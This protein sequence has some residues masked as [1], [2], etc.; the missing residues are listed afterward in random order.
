MSMLSDLRHFIRRHDLLPDGARVV[1][2]VS[3]GP[4]S[5]ALLHALNQLVPEHNWQLHAAYLH[6]GLR[7]EADDEARFVAEVAAAWGLGCTF[8][9]ADV[10]AIAQ[11]PG[12]ALEEAARQARYAFL[13]RVALRLGAH[14]VAVG[15]NADDQAE[16]VLMHLL[17]GSG[18]AGLRGMSPSTPLVGFR[19]LALEPEKRPDMGDLRLVRPLLET[20]RSEIE[21]YCQTHG[22]EPRHDATNTDA[23]FFRNRLRHQIMPGLREINPR[24][25]TVLGRTAATLQGD[26]DTLQVHRQQLWDDMVQS[27]SGRVRIDLQ[28]FRQLLPGDQ[29][30]LLRR[31]VV[32]LRPDLRNISWEH[33]ER[34]LDILDSDPQRTSGG[35]YPLLAGLEAWLHQRWLDILPSDLPSSDQPQ[36]TQPTVLSP[37]GSVGLGP[38]W[39]LE[40]VQTAWEQNSVRP[41]AHEPDQ[42]RIWLPLD[43]AQPL[44]VRP[45]QPGDH[46][47]PL[48]LGG[49]KA[50]NVLMTDL[51]LPRAAR[52]RWPLLLD[53][54]GEILWLVGQRPSESCRLPD[55]AS[56]AWEIRL[57]LTV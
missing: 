46:M 8:E 55:D 36:I 6:H 44:V 16:T 43:V 18:L 47:R 22:L 14:H 21:A 2:G 13:G 37:P 17:R 31:A 53:A 50:I 11:Q 12:V 25:T 56:G 32:T 7:P 28:G 48:G 34:L 29:R 52:A 57:V 27:Q 9:R 35:P 33:T 54:N 26:Y 10:R 42:H 30:S 38:A 23:T 4:D 1:V 51:K 40:A 5:L 45:R 3:G 15:H 19:L 41:W 20:P 39:R 24:L 49:G